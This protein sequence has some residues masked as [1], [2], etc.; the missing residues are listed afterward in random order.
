ML[1]RIQH[2]LHSESDGVSLASIVLGAATSQTYMKNRS[3]CCSRLASIS[4]FSAGTALAES[5]CLR[6]G[7]HTSVR[8]LIHH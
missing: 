8:C 6:L 1:Q 5:L 3:S 2:C 4:S 7:L